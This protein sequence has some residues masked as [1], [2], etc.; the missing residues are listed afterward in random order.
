MDKDTHTK[1]NMTQPYKELKNAFCSNIDG[2]RDD[3]PKGSKVRKRKKN[4][5]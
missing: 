3:H 5:T 1:W 4:I 2:P